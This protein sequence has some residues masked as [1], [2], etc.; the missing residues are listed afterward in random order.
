MGVRLLR[1][2]RDAIRRC[3][4]AGRFRPD[5]DADLVVRQLFASMHGLAQLAHAGHVIG[6]YGPADV[7]TGTLRD[8]A[9]AA[10]DEPGRAGESVRSG[11]ADG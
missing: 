11:L 5:A 8:F 6:V 10:G 3:V 1:H 2:P 9:V 4:A 7:L